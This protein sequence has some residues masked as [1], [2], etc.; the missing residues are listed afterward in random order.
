MGGFNYLYINNTVNAPTLAVRI[1]GDNNTA[2]A[3]NTIDNQ[4][5]LCYE[6]F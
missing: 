2:G 6:L 3:T 5:L 4:S 1:T